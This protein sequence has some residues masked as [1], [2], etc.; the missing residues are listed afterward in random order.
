MCCH[1]LYSAILTIYLYVGREAV[2][3]FLVVIPATCLCYTLDVDTVTQGN[4]LSRSLFCNSFCILTCGTYVTGSCHAL[5][6]RYYYIA[7]SFLFNFFNGMRSI[8]YFATN[9][10]TDI[11]AFSSDVSLLIS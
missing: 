1:V 11:A 5:R 9:T 2:T 7:S 8:T 4:V 6:V 3:P 10:N